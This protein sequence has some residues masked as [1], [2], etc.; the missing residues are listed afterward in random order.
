MRVV[1]Q[2]RQK[3]STTNTNNPWLESSANPMNLLFFLYLL[4][5]DEI[6]LIIDD[7]V[8]I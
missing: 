8:K 3:I 4:Q 1:E 7:S 5:W 6:W 2:V